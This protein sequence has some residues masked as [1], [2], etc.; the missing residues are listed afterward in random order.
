M[1]EDLLGEAHDHWQ[2]Q[3]ADVAFY[4]LVIALRQ[5]SCEISRS[6]SVDLVI[7]RLDFVQHRPNL[8]RRQAGVRQKIAK[9]VE[10]ALE[11]DVVL[12]ERIVG[13]EDKWLRFS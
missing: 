7:D 9:L 12:P 13:A 6:I 11:V 4:Q 1:M 8:A 3:L 5:V 2:V 10:G